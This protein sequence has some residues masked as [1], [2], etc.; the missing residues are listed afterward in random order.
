[1]QPSRS[2]QSPFW[3]LIASF[4]PEL[5]SKTPWEYGCLSSLIS[6]TVCFLTPILLP[7][8]RNSFSF[9]FPLLW[10]SLNWSASSLAI[11]LSDVCSLRAFSG[12]FFVCF[13]LFFSPCFC[14]PCNFPLTFVFSLIRRHFRIEQ[15]LWSLFDFV[16]PG[17]LGTYAVFESEIAH[18][19]ISGGYANATAVKVNRGILIAMNR[20]A[21]QKKKKNQCYSLLYFACALVAV[22]LTCL[23]P[24]LYIVVI[25][26]SFGWV[27]IRLVALSFFNFRASFWTPLF[28]CFALFCFV[29]FWICFCIIIFFVNWY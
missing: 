4:S 24:R 3:R 13:F 11:W 23:W 21:K 15:E 16:Y 6:S 17:R 2:R 25:D 8:S 14:F 28:L 26:V 7:S 18:P 12:S 19:I 9:L 5:P 10:F 1:M 20:G 22:A 27:G 29:F